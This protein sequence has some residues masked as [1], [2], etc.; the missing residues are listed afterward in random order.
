MRH[1]TAGSHRQAAGTSLLTCCRQPSPGTQ[2]MPPC[3]CRGGT[4]GH[5][6]P[7]PSAPPPPCAGGM[8]TWL[9]HD[10]QPAWV[11]PAQLLRQHAL[12]AALTA[13]P[14]HAVTPA[15]R[16]AG[17]L[18]RWARMWPAG[19]RPHSCAAPWLPA[20]SGFRAPRQSW[21]HLQSGR[22]GNA[23]GAGA[24]GGELRRE[25]R[26]RVWWRALA[27][28]AQ[29]AARHPVLFCALKQHQDGPAACLAW[30][31]QTRAS[32]GG[33]PTLAAVVSRLC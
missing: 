21:L 8:R 1:D 23:C 26:R 13:A 14:A 22:V 15:G 9:W 27:S 32:R 29:W 30:C 2:R 6:P 24:G 4:A 18:F 10:M 31:R 28:A 33:S 7:L 3:A 16:L 5:A 17:R 25:R 11:K 19:A 20:S 12:P